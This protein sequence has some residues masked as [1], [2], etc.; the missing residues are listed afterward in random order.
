[1]AQI[2]TAITLDDIKAIVEQIVMGFHPQKVILFGSHAYGTPTP[3]SDVDLLVVMETE[4]NPL[5]TAAKIAGEIDHPFP[6][7]ILVMKPAYLAAALGER[8]L[9]ETEIMAKG[10]VLYE[11]PDPG[12][13]RDRRG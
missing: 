11:E 7:D 3:D 12:M 1:M 9:F 10:I 2:K 8:D 4:G 13:D 5:H 6:M